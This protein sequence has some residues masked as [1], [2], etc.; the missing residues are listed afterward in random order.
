MPASGNKVPIIRD[1]YF[2][3]Q[4][5]GYRNAPCGTLR[6]HCKATQLGFDRTLQW[7]V[8]RFFSSLFRSPDVRMT[9]SWLRWSRST[10]RH[11]SPSVQYYETTLTWTQQTLLSTLEELSPHKSRNLY[12]QLTW[13]MDM[14]STILTMDNKCIPTFQTY[15][16]IGL[17]LI[18]F[19]LIKTGRWPVWQESLI[20][21]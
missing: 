10:W 7:N 4:K 13:Q 6:L 12:R 17:L 18:V 16:T 19:N 1:C 15:Q 11:C 2:G 9:S 14:T 21:L 8:K 20:Q 5:C 3:S